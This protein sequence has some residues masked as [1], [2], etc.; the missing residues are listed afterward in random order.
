[1]IPYLHYINWRKKL[2]FCGVSE[3]LMQAESG[4]GLFS[5][6]RESQVCHMAHRK[7]HS[8]LMVCSR[9]REGAMKGQ[10]FSP[11]KAIREITLLPKVLP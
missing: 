11:A 5:T 1:M 4:S 7:P 6:Y 3:M 2:T 8:S 9:T 10:L